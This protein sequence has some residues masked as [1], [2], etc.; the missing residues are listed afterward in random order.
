MPSRNWSLWAGPPVWSRSTKISLAL[1]ILCVVT[2]LAVAFLRGPLGWNKR[3]PARYVTMGLGFVPALVIFPYV[4]HS[5]RHIRR[6]WHVSRGRLCT[7]CAYDL[8][9]LEPAGICPECGRAYD[10]ESDAL[11]WKLAGLTRDALPPPA[12]SPSATRPEP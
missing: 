7:H 12:A 3:G 10:V 8:S 1:A 9:T 6:A 2:A 11:L 5:R 4:H